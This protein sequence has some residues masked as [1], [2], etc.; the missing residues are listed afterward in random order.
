MDPDQYFGIDLKWNYNKQELT[1]S[2]DSYVDNM[3]GKFNIDHP[4][5]SF[6]KLSPYELP[7]Y[8]QNVQYTETDTSRALTQMK[9]KFIQQVTGKFLLYPRVVDN[10]MP[11]VLNKIATNTI[12]GTQR[13]LDVTHHFL[14]YTACNPK[15]TIIDPISLDV[16]FSLKFLILKNMYKT[17]G[18]KYH[19]CG[20]SYLSNYYLS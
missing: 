11:H 9:M 2:M 7:K 12:K 16:N 8:G 15:A 13:T 3:L 6:Q 14:K 17:Y 18:T 1:C 10:T 19:F 20:R 5:Q 4:K